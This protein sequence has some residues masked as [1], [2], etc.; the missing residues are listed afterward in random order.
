MKARL[1]LLAP[2]S[3]L[4]ALALA[5]ATALRGSSSATAAPSAATSITLSGTNTFLS[6]STI[7]FASGSST[8][9]SG[10]LGGTPSGGTL[11]LSNLALTLGTPIVTDITLGADGPSV[12]S[13]LAAQSH[14]QGMVFDGS[15]VSAKAVLESALG[16]LSATI[17]VQCDV[18]TANPAASRALFHIGT[19]RTEGTAYDLYAIV[20]TSGTLQVWKHGAAGAA[21]YRYAEMTKNLVANFGGKRVHI[22]FVTTGGTLTIYCDGVSEGFSGGSG[23][24]DP[25]WA[26]A[27]AGTLVTMGQAGSSYSW[28]GFLSLR[29]Y[30]RAFSAAEPKA[31]INRGVDIPSDYNRATN[32][33]TVTGNNS[34]FSGSGGWTVSGGAVVGGGVLTLP[35]SGASAYYPTGF[36]GA[37]RKYLVSATVTGSPVTISNLAGNPYGTLSAGTKSTLEIITASTNPTI[38]GIMSEETST[39]DD[40]TCV[41]TGLLLATDSA[42][43]GNGYQLHSI[44]GQTPPVD[45]TL[46]ASGVTWAFPSTQGNKVRATLTWSGT[47]EPKSLLG[48]VAIPANSVITTIITSASAGSA[49][50]GLTVGSVTTPNLFVA[51]VAYTTAKKVHTLAAQLPE[52]TATNDLS[53]VV[54]PDTQ[55]YTGTIQIE[56]HYLLAQ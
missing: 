12:S 47:H 21:D 24:T 40:I 18:P 3:F 29:I 45:I 30:N 7:G 46:P 36:A 16:D 48:Q 37:G 22:A 49:G 28:S 15:A 38:L 32:T 33:S 44:S 26:G 9:I 51:A 42:A 55:N 14:A 23:G 20:S 13:S 52:G 50:S 10:S 53:L 25:T 39:I 31:L 35:T 2:F 6:G 54:D 11:N 8:T 41:A 1:L 5:P 19:A 17:L 56:I 43:P 34:T 27:V 4:L